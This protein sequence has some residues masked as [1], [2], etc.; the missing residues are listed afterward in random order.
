MKLKDASFFLPFILIS[1]RTAPAL[2][3]MPSSEATPLY[4]P[5]AISTNTVTAITSPSQTTSPYPATP[6]PMPTLEPALYITPLPGEAAR[7]QEYQTALA[8]KL[9]SFHPLEEVLC[10]WQLLG[11][12]GSEL[13]AWAVCT[14]TVPVG[15]SAYYSG[16]SVPVLTILGEDG[17][18]LSMDIPGSGSD[19]GRDIREMFPPDV[20]ELV[21]NH[22]VYVGH[23]LPHLEWRR[24]LFP[25]EP[26]LIVFE[27]AEPQPKQ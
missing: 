6:S 20:Q 8:G 18:V 15:D 12:S 3:E 21:F 25:E 13:Y 24:D 4:T 26:P 22:Q 23:L 19:Y 11:R 9:M 1:C 5:Y 27:N 17:S 7:W 10:E 16:I 14:S 2:V